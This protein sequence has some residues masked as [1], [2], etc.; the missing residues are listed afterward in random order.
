VYHELRFDTANGTFVQQLTNPDDPNV[1]RQTGTFTLHDNT[2][3][4]PTW[5]DWRAAQ[6]L[7]QETAKAAVA[8]R[9]PSRYSGSGLR[10]RITSSRSSPESPS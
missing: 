4:D 6:S 5:L 10:R 2:V 7:G 8:A 9:D 3:T 1:P